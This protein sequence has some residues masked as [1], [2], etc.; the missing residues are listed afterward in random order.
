MEVGWEGFVLNLPAWMCTGFRDLPAPKM[1]ISAKEA[2]RRAASAMKPPSIYV[3]R[4]EKTHRKDILRRL[5]GVIGVEESEVD[6]NG[7]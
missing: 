2:E 6:G 1:P 4:S 3:V 5:I 7:D